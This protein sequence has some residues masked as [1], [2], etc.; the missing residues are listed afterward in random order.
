[1]KSLNIFHWMIFY[2]IKDTNS[3]TVNRASLDKYN[4]N[5]VLPLIWRNI[6][7]NFFYAIKYCTYNISRCYFG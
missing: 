4:F 7:S 6:M 1:M 5:A 3:Y 2:Q